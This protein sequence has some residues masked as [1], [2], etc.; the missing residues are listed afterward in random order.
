M[1]NNELIAA[2]FVIFIYLLR[3]GNRLCVIPALFML[4]AGIHALAALAEVSSVEG[5]FDV[6]VV[7]LTFALL[8]QQYKYTKWG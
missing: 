5:W 4:P 3:K 2:L 6:C 8:A 1:D 7:I